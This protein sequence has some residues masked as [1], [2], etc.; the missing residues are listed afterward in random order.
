MNEIPNPPEVTNVTQNSSKIGKNNMWKN[1]LWTFLGTTISILLTFGTGQL[2]QIHRKAN[3]R[4][5]T[6]MMVLGNIEKFAQNLESLSTDLQWRDT[7]STLLL[8]V[9]IDSLDQPEYQPYLEATYLVSGFIV[10]NHDK[11]AEG[12]FSNSIETWKN[13]G[14]FGFIDNVGKCFASMN[15]I[16]DDYNNYARHFGEMQQRIMQTPDAY[17]GA[18][19]YS[20]YL[21]DPE[22]RDALSTLHKRSCYYR[23][24]ASFIRYLNKI[25]MKM[26]DI[27]EEELLQFVKESDV[28][29]ELEDDVPSQLDFITP[30]V[31][32]ESIKEPLKWIKEQ[33][34]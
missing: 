33:S 10:I 7:L 17:E 31:D 28:K 3:D 30:N 8:N 24:L 25:N 18:S 1:L 2:V 21:H 26:T 29:T 16:E 13:M 19:E 5:M 23:Y 32:P 12:I 14:N 27:S 4:K 34:I 9:P 22:Y 6:V 20:K 11:T 15:T